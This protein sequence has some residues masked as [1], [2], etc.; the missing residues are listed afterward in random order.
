[1]SSMGESSWWSARDIALG[2]VAVGRAQQV[3]LA[4]AVGRTLAAEVVAHVDLPGFPTAAMD[5]WVVAGDG[6]WTIVGTIDTGIPA[7][8]FWAPGRTGDAH[9]NRWA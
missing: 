5:G 3:P 8:E 1:M 7:D 4:M 6:P 2:A 9:R